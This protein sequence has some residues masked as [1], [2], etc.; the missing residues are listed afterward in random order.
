MLKISAGTPSRPIFRSSAQATMRL[1]QEHFAATVAQ[2]LCRWITW[3]WRPWKAEVFCWTYLYFPEIQDWLTQNF[4]LARLGGHDILKPGTVRLCDL[5]SFQSNM[6]MASK[7]L[8]SR[9]F[10]IPLFGQTGR[11]PFVRE[12]ASSTLK[13]ALRYLTNGRGAGDV[14][15]SAHRH[16]RGGESTK[17]LPP[18]PQKTI[19]PR[20]DPYAVWAFR[21]WKKPQAWNRCNLQSGRRGSLNV[22]LGIPWNPL[23]TWPNWYAPHLYHDKNMCLFH[24]C[25]YTVWPYVCMYIYMY[26]IEWTYPL[27]SGKLT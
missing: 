13:R 15:G 9:G 7:I 22:P 18:F 17:K 3:P 21:A 10:Q 20:R 14:W 27:P 5:S 23:V 24:T 26:R 11:S 6:A 4:T 25:L 16:E 1:L 12:N 2:C 8:R 19:G